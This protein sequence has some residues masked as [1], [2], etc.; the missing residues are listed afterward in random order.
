MITDPR[1]KN[2]R[3]NEDR[4]NLK[5]GLLFR[6]YF[7]EPVIVQYYQSFI[8]KQIVHKVL[9]RLHGDFGKHPGFFKTLIAYREK[10]YFPKFAQLIRE[11]VVS[12]KQCIKKSRID[13]SLNRPPFKN[14][15]EHNTAPKDAMQT[16]LVP[17]LPPSGGYENIVTAMNVFSCYLFAYP[18]SNQ[19]AKTTASVLNNMMTKHAYL[20]TTR[21]SDKG[22][23]FMSH[24][25][26]ELASPWHYSKSRNYK[27]RSNNWAA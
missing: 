25:I 14:P 22:T 8:P 4:I 26:K 9:R 27:A 20:P 12:C 10:Y 24:V 3:A 15:N 21:I 18:T 23:A 19:D 2:Y 11:W 1:Y 6:K 13:R 5:D 16:D 17:E 7:G